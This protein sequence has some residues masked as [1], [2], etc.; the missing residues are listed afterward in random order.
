VGWHGTGV[1]SHC[2]GVIGTTVVVGV[3]NTEANVG[4]AA[5][6]EVDE[7]AMVLPTRGPWSPS[8]VQN[9]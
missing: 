5:V 6:G 4:A 7:A 9:G 1:A 2:E 3:G 8:S